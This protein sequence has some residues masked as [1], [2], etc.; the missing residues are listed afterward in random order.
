MK[1]SLGWFVCGLLTGAALCVVAALLVGSEI[2][3]IDDN[4]S[5]VTFGS[6]FQTAVSG[7]ATEPVFSVLDTET[8]LVKVYGQSGLKTTIQTDAEGLPSTQ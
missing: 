3:M 5:S 1:S 6:R 7:T 4:D 8:G 2:N